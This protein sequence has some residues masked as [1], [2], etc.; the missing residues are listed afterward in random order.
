MSVWLKIKFLTLPT[1]LVPLLGWVTAESGV[2][3]RAFP[4]L[5]KVCVCVFVILYISSCP[6]LYAQPLNAC[7]LKQRNV[8]SPSLALSPSHAHS[9]PSG[10]CLWKRDV[11]GLVPFW[12]FNCLTAGRNRCAQSMLF[13]TTTSFTVSKSNSPETSITHSSTTAMPDIHHLSLTHNTSVS[14][15][16]TPD[17]TLT[18]KQEGARPGTRIG[19]W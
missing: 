3:W 9:T 18:V 12:V 7:H 14:S 19:Q 16:T 5:R 2:E 8:L 13:C 4:D 15:Q 17:L 10:C 1:R 11:H 6:H